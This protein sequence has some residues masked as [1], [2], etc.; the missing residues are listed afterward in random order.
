MPLDGGQ[1]IRTLLFSRQPVLEALFTILG[2][3]AFAALG[4]GFGEPVLAFVGLIIL[5]SAKEQVRRGR[6]LYS[7]RKN[8]SPGDGPEEEQLLRTVYSHIW[9][10]TAGGLNFN[11]RYQLADY[12][13]SN[14]KTSLAGVRQTLF[15]LGVYG[16]SLLIFPST[17]FIIHWVERK[18]ATEAVVPAELQ[19][20]SLSTSE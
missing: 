6:L 18:V 7:L 17:M 11:R 9:T 15:L 2:G 1:V 8:L 5:V 4:L 12:L 20:V 10:N 16:F 13:L 3:V 19:P 14:V